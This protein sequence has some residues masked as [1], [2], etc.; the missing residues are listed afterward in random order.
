MQSIISL[1]AAAVRRLGAFSWLTPALLR[2]AVGVTFISA[3]WGKLHN[4]GQVTAYFESLGIPA[5]GVQAPMVSTIELVGG[6]MVLLG[7]GTRVAAALLTGVMAVAALTAIWPQ[8]DGVVALLGS[9]EIAYLLV[10]VHLVIHGAGPA[11]L[12]HVISRTSFTRVTGATP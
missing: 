11:S 3:G 12:D 6:L 10:F 1:H 4:L 8:A 9:I 5:A 2:V 7:L